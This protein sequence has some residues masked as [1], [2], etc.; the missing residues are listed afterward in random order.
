MLLN[1]RLVTLCKDLKAYGHYWRPCF[2]ALYFTH[3]LCCCHAVYFVAFSSNMG[4]DGEIYFSA[5][6]VQIQLLQ[7][8]SINQC[9]GIVRI[10]N[11][12]QRGNGTFFRAILCRREF[13]LCI[14]IKNLVKVSWTFHSS[15]FKTCFYL[16]FQAE[17][18]QNSRLLYDYAFRMFGNNRIT[19]KTFY[20]VFFARNIK[21]L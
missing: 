3:I 14:G 12:I 18:L 2:T 5:V 21:F 9:A 19:A 7:F 17:S 8:F 1:S 13:V 11:Q 4:L 15:F 20:M 10:N 16:D 6:A